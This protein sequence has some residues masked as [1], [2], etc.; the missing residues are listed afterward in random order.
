MND[1]GPV[2]VILGCVSEKNRGPSHAKDL[3][4]SPLFQ[5]RRRYAEAAG[6]PWVI[7]SA[8]HGIVEPD[9]VLNWYDVSLKD[10]PPRERRAKGEQAVRQL[11]EI[12]GSLTGMTFEIHAGAAYREALETPLARRGASL[13]NQIEGLRFGEQLQWYD[14]MAV[15]ET[16]TSGGA[17]HSPS[18]RAAAPPRPRVFHEVAL[19]STRPTGPLDWRWPDAVEH[20]ERGWDMEVAAGGSLIRVRHAIGS[21]PAYGRTR[22][23]SVTWVGGQPTVEGVEADSFEDTGALISVLKIGGRKHVRSRSEIPAGYE[24]FPIVRHDDEIRA[25]YSR[26]SLAVKIAADDLAGWSRH[27][28]LRA[29]SKQADQ[30]VTVRKPP[31]SAPPVAMRALPIPPPVAFDREA[32]VDALLDFGAKPTDEPTAEPQ[33]TPDPE[34]NRLVIDDPFAFLLA[35]IFDQG[36]LAERAWAAPSELGRRLGHLDPKQMADDLPAIVGAVQAIPKLHRYIEKMPRWLHAAAVRVVDQYEGDAGRIWGDKPTAVDLQVRLD[37]FAGVGQKKAAMA[38]EIL[39]RDLGVTIRELKGSDIAYDVHVRRVLLRTG[40]AERDDLDHM[41]EVTRA[42][43][44]DRP[45]AIDFPAWRIGREW[46]RPGIPD[47][48]A[49]PLEAV[50]PK[51]VDRAAAVRGA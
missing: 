5:K 43:N 46:C 11:E 45:G 28:L 37:A 29:W 20:F 22:V 42:A 36:V 35:V 6:L 8:E 48:P 41:L 44:P 23:H 50:C 17:R 30:A 14:R 9:T 3:Y 40:L 13:T 2:A 51:L 21:R 12:F 26:R 15:G 34:A 19:R 39:E 16:T 38:V 18:V 31:I 33:F 7:F 1:P 49:C 32:V 25:P 10:L 4:V 27:A 47:C 24:G